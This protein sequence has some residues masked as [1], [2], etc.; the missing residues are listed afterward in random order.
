MGWLGLDWRGPSQGRTPPIEDAAG[1]YA[2]AIFRLLVA[3]IVVNVI[4]Y[5]LLL[6]RIQQP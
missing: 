4:A 1:F 6:N 5:F 2:R 3:V